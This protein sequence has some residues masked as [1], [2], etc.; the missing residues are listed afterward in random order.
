MTDDWRQRLLDAIERSPLS[1][2]EICKRAGVGSSFVSDLKNAGKDPKAA[3][4]VKVVSA[5][6]V[7]LSYVFA[8][9]DISP[10]TEEVVRIWTQLPK[11][12]RSHLLALARG[13][14]GDEPLAEE[15]DAA[16]DSSAP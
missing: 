4:V 10:E 5:L 2:R 16:R 9:I 3:S 1:D 11:E 15:T 14:A 12:M 13:L 7:S 8:G 6:D